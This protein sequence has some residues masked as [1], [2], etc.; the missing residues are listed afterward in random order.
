MHVTNLCRQQKNIAK[1]AL[2]FDIFAMGIFKFLFISKAI[3]QQGPGVPSGKLLEAR[4]IF[5]V[6][7]ALL[8]GMVGWGWMKRAEKYSYVS[9]KIEQISTA[10]G[11]N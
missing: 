9:P 6:G 8:A 11:R 4:A 10:A 7:I 5:F 3:R 2:W 1:K